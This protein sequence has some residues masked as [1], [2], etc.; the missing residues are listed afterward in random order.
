MKRLAATMMFAAWLLYGAMPA[1]AMP[2]MTTMS[3]APQPAAEAAHDHGQHH[4]MSGGTGQPLANPVQADHPSHAHND[5][6]KP[7]PHGSGKGCVA[8]FCAACLVLLPDIALADTGRFIHPTPVPQDAPSLVISAARP[9]I[10]PPR[11]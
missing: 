7:C 1:M 9:P 2:G 3:M 8:P 11:A 4:D 5:R 6:S 10:P